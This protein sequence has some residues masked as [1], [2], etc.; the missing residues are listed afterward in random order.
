MFTKRKLALL[1]LIFTTAIGVGIAFPT[2]R[3]T[4]AIIAGVTAVLSV[5]FY[6]LKFPLKMDKLKNILIALTASFSAF[7]LGIVYLSLY[8]AIAIPDLSSI[9]NDEIYLT[10]TILEV[11]YNEYYNTTFAKIKVDSSDHI[12]KGTVLSA[13][14][15]D[16]MFSDFPGGMVDKH[17]RIG[18]YAT[19]DSDVSASSMASG[20]DLYAE[21]RPDS[22]ERREA[23]GVNKVLEDFSGRIS[24]FFDSNSFWDN[25]TKGLAK[26]VIIN[27][28]SDMDAKLNYSFRRSGIIHFLSISGFH[29]TIVTGALLF[30]LKICRVGLK[31]RVPICIIFAFF[32]SMMVG[33]VPSVTRSLVM[34]AFGLLAILFSESSD[35]FTSISV[36]LLFILILNPFAVADIGLQL[37]FLSVAGI[38]CAL[39]YTSKLS[40]KLKMRGEKFKTANLAVRYLLSPLLVTLFAF[41]F[42]LPVVFTTFRE[43]PLVSPIFNLLAS[44]LLSLLLVLF[45]VSA[46]FGVIWS[47]LAV[48]FSFTAGKI[49]ELIFDASALVSGNSALIVTNSRTMFLPLVFLSASLVFIL[50]AS[51]KK[52]RRVALITLATSV[53][54]FVSVS[55]YKHLFMSNSVNLTAINTNTYS[56]L[57]VSSGPSHILFDFSSREINY[58]ELSKNDII[59]VTT[60]VFDSLSARTVSN[61]KILASKGSLRSVYVPLPEP[62][63]VE[64]ANTI[65]ALGDEY[66]FDVSFYGT[67]HSLNFGESA[68][69]LRFFTSENPRR[70]FVLVAEFNDNAVMYVGAMK[71]VPNRYIEFQYCSA[72][73]LSNEFFAKPDFNALP[74][75]YDIPEIFAF[76]GETYRLG[77]EKALSEGGINVREADWLIN[78]NSYVLTITKDGK[79]KSVKE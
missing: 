13:Y 45:F 59:N 55:V 57:V 40:V 19:L 10:G 16:G 32:Y 4:L 18:F 61:I 49:S 69:H 27:E 6:I 17:D 30:I 33:F 51:G 50:L 20:I 36:A 47:P 38:A 31:V 56:H 28:T 37:S 14:L 29:M 26:A 58:S 11:D 39:N 44:P 2:F 60:G 77:M 43:A 52:Q 9:P 62:D 21:I 34:L 74:D 65:S 42:T 23:E 75:T 66:G 24:E 48:P 67:S 79:I 73:M 15:D 68:G 78:G 7:L 25:E 53:L 22:I 64:K 8:S 63:D 46:L 54:V 5:F 35:F 76:D 70:G 71:D 41:L 1:V 3:V 72:M 12:K